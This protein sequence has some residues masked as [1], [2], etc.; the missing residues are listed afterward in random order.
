MQHIRPRLVL[1][2]AMAGVVS[3][4]LTVTAISARAAAG[5]GVTYTVSSQWPGGFGANVNVNNLGDPVSGWRLTWSFAAGQTITQLWNGTVSQ[6]RRAGHRHQCGL[7]C[8]HPHRAQRRRRLQRVVEHSAQ[9][10]ADELRPQRDHVHGRRHDDHDDEP[11]A[12]DHD[13][14]AHDHDPAAHH[15]HAHWYVAEQLPLELQRHPISPEA[16]RHPQ[17]RRDQGPVGRLRTTAS[18]TCSRSTASVRRLQP[19]VPELH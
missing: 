18:T 16:G 10:G 11:P 6:S 9:P 12:H 5:C 3:V 14:A 13:P 2:S 1:A 4:A 7:E 15:D 19:G 8:Q 17:D